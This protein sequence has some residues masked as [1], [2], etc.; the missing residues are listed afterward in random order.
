VVDA[1]S[2]KVLQWQD[3]S[4]ARARVTAGEIGWPDRPESHLPVEGFKIGSVLEPSQFR[5]Q[6]C[7]KESA[8][9]VPSRVLVNGRELEIT[10]ASGGEP[11]TRG[12][13]RPGDAGWFL[14]YANEASAPWR[15]MRYAPREKV[16]ETLVR[17]YAS[18]S[19]RRAVVITLDHYDDKIAAR[20]WTRLLGPQIHIMSNNEDLRLEVLRRLGRPG[21]L[22]RE[23]AVPDLGLAS[24]T[25][26]V[27]TGDDAAYEV[28]SSLGTALGYPVERTDDKAVWSDVLIVPR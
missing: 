15:L 1:P 5:V 26:L 7:E 14:L 27:P 8:T 13:C 6:W 20:F 28:A 9:R 22:L 11:F 16:G 4:G 19:R 25:I 18:P 2:E 17:V 23:E 12:Q 24:S 21:L 3:L 10:W